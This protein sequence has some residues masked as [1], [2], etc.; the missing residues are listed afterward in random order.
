MKNLV[1]SDI[2]ET[3][4]F[5][6]IISENIKLAI[7]EIQKN[8]EFVLATGHHR[9]TTEKYA[10]QL[11]ASRYIITSNGAEVFDRVERK[12]IYSMPMDN[13]A[14]IELYNFAKDNNLTIVLNALYDYKFT[15]NK[16]LINDNTKY[17]SD[18]NQ[19]VDKYKILCIVFQNFTNE[20]RNVIKSKIISTNNCIVANEGKGSIDTCSAYTNKGVAAKKLIKY[21]KAD[22]N[23][24][25]SFGNGINDFSM[26][27]AT[28]KSFAVNN[29]C[30]EIKQVADY[31]IDDVKNDGVAK[32]LLNII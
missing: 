21:L 15:N 8:G 24:T 16:Q 18:I 32:F 1:I 23:N 25:Y 26:F 22:Y 9:S 19:V 28:S 30:E 31:I 14:V 2:D 6:G 10:Q 4:K 29:A 5:N 11:N 17:F 13:N 7:N 20:L 27:A 3:I 12:V